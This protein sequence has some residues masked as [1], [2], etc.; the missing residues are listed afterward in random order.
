[1][2]EAELSSPER[3]FVSFLGHQAAEYAL[4]V[5]LVAAGVHL[6]TSGVA[7]E[8]LLVATGCALVLL[9]VL[10]NG[11]LGAVS[12][13]SRR[14]HRRLDLAIVV[15]LVLSPLFQI[16]QPSAVAIVLGE[17][18]AL[19]LWRIERRTRYLDP[20]KRAVG[21]LGGTPSATGG[22]EAL[23]AKVTTAA[24]SIGGAAAALR[25]ALGPAAGRAVHSGARGLGRAV[26]GA[27]RTRRE[28]SARQRPGA[29]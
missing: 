29:S 21:A 10:T 20:P 3:S 14:A 26:G 25:D 8:A 19:L 6:D 22:N 1:M 13:V 23:G 5:A 15:G 7:P 27:R 4:G 18:L 9:G 11:P 12:L 16:A 2:S 17:A 28:Q 24:S